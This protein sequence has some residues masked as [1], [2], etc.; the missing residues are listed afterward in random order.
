MV[1]IDN[2]GSK[3]IWTV[4]GGFSADF[5]LLKLQSRTLGHKAEAFK[6]RTLLHSVR[7]F[8]VPY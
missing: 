2:L 4:P 6:R 8:N 5:K 1:L 3:S 7:I